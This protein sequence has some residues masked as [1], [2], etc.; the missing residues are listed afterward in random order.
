MAQWQM[1][2]ESQGKAGAVD[3]SP[4]TVAGP[5]VQ[6]NDEQ[7]QAAHA[8]LDKALAVVAAAGTGKTTTMLE[9][10]RYLMS[11]ASPGQQLFL[12][13]SLRV[14]CGTVRFQPA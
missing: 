7:R 6:L 5:H 4:T 12:Q 13:A 1:S 8:P 14:Y 2:P 11:Q 10:C 3:T 9:R